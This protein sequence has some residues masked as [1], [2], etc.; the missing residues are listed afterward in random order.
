MLIRAKV[1]FGTS[2]V[3]GMNGA[4]YL[5]QVRSIIEK[6]VL[7][8]PDMPLV[9]YLQAGFALLIKLFSR[10]SLENSIFLAI[11]LLMC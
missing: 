11:K 8:E 5:V 9:F 10:L 7:G 2:L 4:Y 3:P 6:G 1:M